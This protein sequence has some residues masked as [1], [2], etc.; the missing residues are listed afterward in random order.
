MK[1]DIT[2]LLTIHN[3][4][5]TL[6]SAQSK[7]IIRLSIETT[8]EVQKIAKKVA[9]MDEVTIRSMVTSMVVDRA[10]KLGLIDLEDV[11]R[12]RVRL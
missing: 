6:M 7:K 9:A 4:V 5:Q 1:C 10:C 3:G 8:L 12:I 11:E 2:H